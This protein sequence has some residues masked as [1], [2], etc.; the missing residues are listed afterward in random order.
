MA[1]IS[2]SRTRQ[3]AR[4]LYALLVDAEAH[5]VE[6][7]IDGQRYP[8]IVFA[9]AQDRDSARSSVVDFLVGHGWLKAI[10]RGTKRVGF[11]L[12]GL[13]D[14]ILDEAASLAA[15]T[16]FAIVADDEPITN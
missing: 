3:L 6:E 5:G 13:A 14:P 9:R 2:R 15:A 4:H 1:R 10:V 12:S 8:L 16:G 11:D 7:R